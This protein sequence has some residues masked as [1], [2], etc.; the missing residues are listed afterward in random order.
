MKLWRAAHKASLLMAVG[1]VALGLYSRSVMGRDSLCEAAYYGR[2]GEMRFLLNVGA[3]PN[4]MGWDT[5]S[6]PL[7]D[8]VRGGQLGAAHLLLEWGADPNSEGRSAINLGLGNWGVDQTKKQ[9]V[10]ALLRS[11]GG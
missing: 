4:R 8:A 2:L 7:S 10:V 6:T 5:Y 1:C 9:P 11:A 3:D